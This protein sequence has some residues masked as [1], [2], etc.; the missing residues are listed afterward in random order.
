MES[1]QANGFDDGGH[2][3][4][5]QAVLSVPET[6]AVE[7]GSPYQI[8]RSITM[9]DVLEQDPRPA[10]VIDLEDNTIRT[11]LQPVF[12]NRAFRNVPGLT[13]VV[14]GISPPDT[15]GQAAL[16]TYA[17]FKKWASD[18][19]GAQQ[20][21]GFIYH[22]MTWTSMTINERWRMVNGIKERQQDRLTGAFSSVEWGPKALPVVDPM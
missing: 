17:V 12:Q 20:P 6:D 11:S 8:F 15:Y 2:R 9:I 5:Q 3:N 22:G 16:S 13:E 10:F 14:T 21:A 7:M 4:T 19:T 1:S 18:P